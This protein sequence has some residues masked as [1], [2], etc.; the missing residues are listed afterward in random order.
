MPF[1]GVE[2]TGSGRAGG[3]SGSGAGCE[4]MLIPVAG[5]LVL[6]L[7]T[8]S[9]S[10]AGPGGGRGRGCGCGR[11]GDCRGGARIP[12]RWGLAGA[13]REGS[14][15]CSSSTR[16]RLLIFPRSGSLACASRAGRRREGDGPS[17]CRADARELGCLVGDPDC[18]C[19]LCG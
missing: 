2:E 5:W 1:G 7:G 9:L 3:S 13:V 6:G 8:N 15:S 4:R 10:P 11:E 14:L 19:L 12:P 17:L 16:R 18:R